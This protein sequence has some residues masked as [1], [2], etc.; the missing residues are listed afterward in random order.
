MV[1]PQ[2]HHAADKAP[3]DSEFAELKERVLVVNTAQGVLKHLKE[4]AR[5]RGHYAT[6][7]VWELMQNARD[8]A[9]VSQDPLTV[10]VIQCDDHLA[11]EHDGGSFSLDEVAHLIYHGSTK[12]EDKGAVGEFGSGFLT[13]HLLS[14]EIRVSGRL[15]RGGGFSFPLVRPLTSVA[16]MSSAMDKAYDEFKNS[17]SPTSGNDV[18]RFEYSI[19]PDAVG[20]VTE[21]VAE[22]RACAPY[23][24]AFNED[25]SEVRI[26]TSDV[27]TVFT[28]AKR[29]P[30]PSLD[31]VLRVTVTE[32]TGAATTDRCYLVAKSED[33]MVAVP[34][35]DTRCEA[36]GSI[37]RLFKGF[38][39]VS[40]QDFSFPAVINSLSFKPTERRDGVYIDDNNREN[41]AV[42]CTA[43]NLFV[44]ICKCV[45]SDKLQAAH[46]LATF[47]PVHPKAGLDAA[48]LTRSL[49]D[50]IQRIRQTVTIHTCTDS[51][52]SS[53]EAAVPFVDD[54]DPKSVAELWRLLHRIRDIRKRLVT[55]DESLGWAS[56][57][58]SWRQLGVTDLNEAFHGR[59]LIQSIIGRSGK[60]D[61]YGTIRQL[62]KAL[63]E[64]DENTLEW[65]NQCHGFFIRIGLGEYAGGHEIVPS[66]DGIL[67]KLNDLHRDT[68]VGH[69][70]KEIA[71]V[72][73]WSL[74]LRDQTMSVFEDKPGAGNRDAESVTAKLINLVKAESKTIDGRFRKASVRLFGWLVRQQQW[75]LLEGYPVYSH[76][77][78]ATAIMLGDARPPL[79]PVIAWELAAQEFGD[80]FSAQ[81]IVAEEFF[82]V[83]SDADAWRVLDEHDL[84]RHGPL[85]ESR[86]QIK[87]MRLDLDIDEMAEDDHWSEEELRVTEIAHM[88]GDVGIME[89]VRK[90]RS[91]A[92]KLWCFMTDYLIE[93]KDCVLVQ[94]ARCESGEEHSYEVSRWLEPVRTNKWIPKGKRRTGRA[95]AQSVAQLL[96]DVGEG[97]TDIWTTLGEPQSATNRLLKAIGIAPIDVMREWNPAAASRIEE[98]LQEMLAIVRG[99]IGRL[100]EAREMLEKRA[101]KRETVRQNQR[102][103]QCVE[104]EVQ[105]CLEDS[106]FEVKRRHEGAD[107]EISCGMLQVVGEKRS[108]LV[109]IKAT[110]TT[111]VRMSRTQGRMAVDEGDGYLLCVVPIEGEDT[112]ARDTVRASLRFVRNIGSRLGTLV[113]GADRLQEEQDKLLSEDIQGVRLEVDGGVE[114][115]RIS[116]TVW[117]G[118]F[119]ITELLAVL[120]RE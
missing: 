82:A 81:V 76:A 35:S 50:L 2:E 54:D 114:R 113:D 7:W 64:S 37:P 112:P 108:W 117:A 33:T 27:H 118:G 39:L 104:K 55:E 94:Q 107:L 72:L 66:Q 16:E 80:L 98:C 85:I 31:Q 26:R 99:D 90:S 95:D 62:G 106:G 5:Q 67:H 48:W 43:S 46:R 18:T 63:G 28:M 45:S 102:L 74:D 100:Q 65:L 101:E 40:T 57:L 30:V 116:E 115:F 38:P 103:G 41:K 32:T 13:T 22:L 29:A 20:T 47:P 53:A 70:L 11:F 83:V 89:R 68:G 96:R 8:A 52:M 25:F 111:V 69:D 78:Q 14:S 17:L 3:Q 120:R 49:S 6:R 23:I 36:L 1:P 110:R 15:T 93:E 97:A 105:K 79:A 51:T 92:Y 24:L 73:G 87:A 91:L 88:T 71:R 61:G 12:A 119:P 59:V 84:V 75:H 42:I 77:D 60:G 19:S 34:I 44:E 86:K 58:R 10:T 21:G 4:M 9:R 56:A 109:E